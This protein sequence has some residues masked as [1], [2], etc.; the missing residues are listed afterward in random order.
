MTPWFIAK[1][2]FTPRSGDAWTK[3]I[4]W[5][6]LTQLKEV[7][8]LDGLLCPRVLREVKDEYWPHIVNEDCMLA[9]FIDF[10][11]LMKQVAEIEAKNVLCVF[12]DPIKQP[13]PPSYATFEFLGYDLVDKECAI[14]ALTNCGGFPEAFSNTELSSVGLIPEF[15]RAVEVQRLLRSCFPDERHADC[16]LWAIF[17]LVP[18]EEAATA[19]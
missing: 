16:H 18:S 11:Y 19:F 1:E 6:G 2:P 12:R 14:S 4:E 3:Y 5:S 13:E 8:S 10:D 17:R 15:A 9:H 7:V